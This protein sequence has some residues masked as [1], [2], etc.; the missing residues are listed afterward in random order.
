MNNLKRTGLLILL[1]IFGVNTLTAQQNPCNPAIYVDG[2]IGDLTHTVY[3]ST[4]TPHHQGSIPVYQNPSAIAFTF[5]GNSGAVDVKVERW[6]T[7][8]FPPPSHTLGQY[9]NYQ[10]ISNA[11][12]SSGPTTTYSLNVSNYPPGTY[13]VE[14]R[15]GSEPNIKRNRCLPIFIISRTLV[16]TTTFPECVKAGQSI[17]ITWNGGSGGGNVNLVLR[18]TRST[19]WYVPVNISI[20][21]TGSYNLVVPAGVLPNEMYTVE[22]ND[23]IQYVN[24]ATS[25]KICPA[26]RVIR[27]T[28][29]QASGAIRP[30]IRSVMNAVCSCGSWE[31]KQ[32]R[33]GDAIKQMECGGSLNLSRNT[34]ANFNLKYNCSSTDC[35][36]R[37]E[38]VVTSPD[39]QANTIQITNNTAWNYVFSQAGNYTITFKTYCNDVLCTDSCSYSFGVK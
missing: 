12:M 1:S 8:G 2:W 36:A 17:P 6:V 10:D 26:T 16:N 7:Y 39:G 15:C 35:T 27:G 24:A 23:G 9:D 28:I 33:Y 11:F 29:Q 5:N 25:L 19:A 32:I 13:T 3:P 34:S 38:A 14:S 20:P 31:T 22:I 21:N 4:N 18:T 37:Y 30:N